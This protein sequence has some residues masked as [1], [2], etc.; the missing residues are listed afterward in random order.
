MTLG[1]KIGMV[2]LFCFSFMVY[3]L[4]AD[5]THG[6]KEVLVHRD[7]PGVKFRTS[8]SMAIL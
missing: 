5:V 2:F 7:R 3:M 4:C 6:W 1:M 8:L